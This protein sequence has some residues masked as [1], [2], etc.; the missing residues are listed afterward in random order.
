M[1]KQNK[2]LKIKKINKIQKDY[3]LRLW[4]GLVATPLNRYKQAIRKIKNK[5]RKI[6]KDRLTEI[7]V[8]NS[9]TKAKKLKIK[10]K[11]LYHQHDSIYLK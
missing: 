1:I 10:L 2:S 4:I 3:F 9:K 8:L 6:M 5:A 7:W 11:M